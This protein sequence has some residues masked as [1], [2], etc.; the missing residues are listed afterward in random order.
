MSD[1]K[2]IGQIICSSCGKHFTGVHYGGVCPECHGGHDPDVK[3]CPKCKGLMEY[4]PVTDIWELMQEHLSG[5]YGPP[6]LRCR[7][8]GHIMD[9]TDARDYKY[10]LYQPGAEH[11]IM[12]EEASSQPG[13]E[14]KLTWMPPEEF[15]RYVDP[16]DTPD[17]AAPTMQNIR[18]RLKTGQPLDPLLLDKTVK[19][20]FGYHIYNGKH[21]ATVA[22]SLG[23]KSVPVVVVSNPDSPPHQQD[24]R[25]TDGVELPV[26]FEKSA[27]TN[28]CS[29]ATLAMW[30][31]N[32]GH[33]VDQREINRH[34]AFL[35]DLEP[36]ILKYE[37]VEYAPYD[38]DRVITSLREGNPVMLMLVLP[39]GRHKVVATGFRN[40]GQEILIHDPDVGPFWPQDATQLKSEAERAVYY[41]PDR[42]ATV[43]RY[44]YR[45]AHQLNQP[46]DRVWESDAVRGFREHAMGV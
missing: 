32:Y 40:G 20:P 34:G 12:V 31:A 17:P 30:L 9:D 24:A 28:Y 44:A 25:S 10:N 22:K 2:P 14:V 42:G 18:E 19:D 6:R 26:P 21:R 5:Q 43:R 16:K 38:H 3:V 15:L 45:L 46:Y 8:C 23:L 29:E 13:D 33:R 39:R 11:L 41:D 27:D 1:G 36:Y 37:G 35:E 7:T 4:I